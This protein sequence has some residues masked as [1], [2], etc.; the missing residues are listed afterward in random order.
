MVAQDLMQK[1]RSNESY[2][3]HC[4]SQEIDM[5]RCNSKF[6]V[7]FNVSTS[8]GD[9]LIR[10][11]FLLNIKIFIQPRQE[12]QEALQNKNVDWVNASAYLPDLNRIGN[13]WVELKHFASLKKSV[14]I[15]QS[16]TTR[17]YI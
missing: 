15:N 11:S 2:L 17:S 7:N 14:R 1:I 5:D 4:I 10:A 3:G 12:A 13:L 6:Q 16:S 9:K 8:F